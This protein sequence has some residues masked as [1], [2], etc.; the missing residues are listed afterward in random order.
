MRG[1]GNGPT[2][3]DHNMIACLAP[4]KLSHAPAFWHEAET[5]NLKRLMLASWGDG[6]RLSILFSCHLRG[7]KE[8]RVV[9]RG[10]RRSNGDRRLWMG[11]FAPQCDRL[12]IG[13]CRSGA[14]AETFLV[15]NLRSAFSPEKINIS[16]TAGHSLIIMVE[17]M[18]SSTS[19][20]W[21]PEFCKAVKGPRK[22]GSKSLQVPKG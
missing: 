9:G 13:L 5:A 14:K 22:S 19:F 16:L 4:R 7:L 10:G 11:S 3:P 12:W 2:L 21:P 17:E 1:P 6:L 8:N 18:A 15:L 20:H